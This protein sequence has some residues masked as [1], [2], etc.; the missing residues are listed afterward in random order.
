[1]IR[2]TNLSK[3]FDSTLALDKINLEVQEG[4]IYGLVGTNGSGK[5][6][7]LKHITGIYMPTEGVVEIDN[8]PS[9]DNEKIKQR[10]GFTPDDL[11]FFDNYSLDD[12]AKM[13][14]G[15]YNNWNQDRFIAMTDRFELRRDSRINRFSKGMQKQAA[16]ILSLATMP[17]YLILDEPVDGLDPIKRHMVWQYIIDDVSD[18]N[19]TALVSS[20]NLKE[21]EGV[22]DT[23]GI[24]DKGKLVIQREL[25]EL[26]TNIHKIQIAFKD[27]PEDLYDNIEILNIKQVGSVDLIIARGD[28]DK[29]ESEL[30]AHNPLI[31]DILP[32]TLEEIFIYELGG[33]DNE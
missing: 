29:I 10:V 11:Y 2:T 20:H 21:I 7:L 30:E 27:K 24:L 13:Y 18:R 16:F 4:S 14:S 25:D 9:Y 19:M 1:M 8:E 12:M 26:K 15:L 5:T 22:C 6:T 17:N 33:L 23:V 3:R 31:M 32:L 28:R